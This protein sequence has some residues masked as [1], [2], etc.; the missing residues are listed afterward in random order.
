MTS[1]IHLPRP[2]PSIF[3]HQTPW[4]TPVP[5]AWPYPFIFHHQTP[6]FKPVPV[7]WPRPFILHHQIPWFKPAAWPYDLILSSSQPNSLIQTAPVAWPCPFILH[8]QTPWP[9][10]FIFQHQT[11]WFK[12]VPLTWPHPFI[13]Y[14]MLCDASSSIRRGIQPIKTTNLACSTWICRW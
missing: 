7:A 11:P 8:H 12:P 10:L 4:F 3:H 13:L 1:S 14:A 2:H 5:M 6:W 9:Y